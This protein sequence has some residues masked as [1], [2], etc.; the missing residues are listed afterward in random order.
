MG[1]DVIYGSSVACT[2]TESRLVDCAYDTNTAQC[3]H[4][5]DAGVICSTQCEL[6]DSRFYSRTTDIFQISFKTSKI[7]IRTGPNN[8]SETVQGQRNTSF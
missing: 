5:N 4:A 6:Q 2:S 3:T 7:S 1:A 8:V